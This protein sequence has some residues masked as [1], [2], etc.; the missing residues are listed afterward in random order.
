MSQNILGS[1]R[2]EQQEGL[3]VGEGARPPG[4]REG[5]WAAFLGMKPG[6]NVLKGMG[7]PVLACPGERGVQ[8]GGTLKEESAF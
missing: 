4:E 2:R 8:S 6:K 3:R 5:E 1:F 7:S